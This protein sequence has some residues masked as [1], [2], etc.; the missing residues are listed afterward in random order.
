[1][2]AEPIQLLGVD[3]SAYARDEMPAVKAG[4]DEP[5]TGHGVTWACSK[6]LTVPEA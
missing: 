5:V 1:M 6:L 3:D 2:G 4:H